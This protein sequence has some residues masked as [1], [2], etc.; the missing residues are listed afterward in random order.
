MFWKNILPPFSGLKDSYS[1]TCLHSTRTQMSTTDLLV[2]SY[3]LE[4]QRLSQPP[5]G[6][7]VMS[8][9]AVLYKYSCHKML[10]FDI[11]IEVTQL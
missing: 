4:F 5:S 7:P 8:N 3:F 10:K 11:L 2:W 6:I 1:P 9:T